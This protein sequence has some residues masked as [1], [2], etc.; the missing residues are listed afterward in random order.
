MHVIHPCIC[1]YGVRYTGYGASAAEHPKSEGT[2]KR[3]VSRQREISR[4]AIPCSAVSSARGNPSDRFFRCSISHF[5]THIIIFLTI[6]QQPS[7]VFYYLPI[8]RDAY[9]TRRPR[10]DIVT[11]SVTVYCLSD[12]F[13]HAYKNIITVSVR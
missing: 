7:V 9:E 1:R 5:S 6:Y 11:I 13:F 10:Y 2:A 12:L 4:T 8:P 3:G